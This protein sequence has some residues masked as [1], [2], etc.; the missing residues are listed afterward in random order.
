[1][2]HDATSAACHGAQQQPLTRC[3]S[4]LMSNR[5]RKPLTQRTL[6]VFAT[7]SSG[8]ANPARP[9]ARRR[10]ARAQRRGA[11]LVR[12]AAAPPGAVRRRRGRVAGPG[13]R[14]P[15]LARAARRPRGGGRP[16]GG[17]A[18]ARPASALSSVW[19]CEI[20]WLLSRTYLKAI[21]PSLKFHFTRMQFKDAISQS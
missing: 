9:A 11:G 12:R 7:I 3:A 10:G 6:R 19:L 17:C 18:A 8:T 14:A 20:R 16:A 1:M 13:R 15:G 5:P 2:Q 21:F 4:A